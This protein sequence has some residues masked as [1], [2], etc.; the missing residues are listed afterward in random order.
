MWELLTGE[1]PYAD[2]RCAAIIGEELVMLKIKAFSCDISSPIHN[3]G[4]YHFI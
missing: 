4:P 2:M 1:E 3:P